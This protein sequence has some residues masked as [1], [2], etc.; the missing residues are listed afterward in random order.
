MS[1]NGNIRMSIINW[2]VKGKK[3]RWRTI[4]KDI[5][6]NMKKTIRRRKLLERKIQRNNTERKNKQK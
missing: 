3:A 4:K 2:N 5:T 6:R 1:I